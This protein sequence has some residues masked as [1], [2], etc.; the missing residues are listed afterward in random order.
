M[1]PVTATALIVGGAGLEAFGAIQEGK[2]AKEAADFNAAVSRSDAE[3][4][5]Q[6]ARFDQVRQAKEASRIKGTMA[7]RA[8]ATGAR[9]D[10]GA[11]VLAAAD[12]AAEL[13]LDNL[14]IGFEGETRAK[15]LES[16]AALDEF[17][18]KVAKQASKIK[19]GS[20][21]LKGFGAAAMAG[22]MAS[23]AGKAGVPKATARSSAAK[24]YHGVTI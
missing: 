9:T 24:S 19:A 10:V 23:K 8:G 14:L 5:R 20:T 13:E 12:Q 4:A 11:P 15:R 17:G 18:G 16:Q 3:A 6:K 22:G 21:L 1:D 7:A 2:S